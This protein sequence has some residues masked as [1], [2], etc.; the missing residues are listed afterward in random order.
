[1]VGVAAEES[2][3]N[4]DLSIRSVGLEDLHRITSEVA[5]KLGGIGGGHANATG[6][7]IPR[8]KL[9]EFIE[10]LDEKLGNF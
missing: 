9:L 5:E 6:A 2:G 3:G 1:V 4:M 10:M 7:R 8:G